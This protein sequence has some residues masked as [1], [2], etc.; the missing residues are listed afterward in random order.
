MR[1]IDHVRCNLVVDSGQPAIYYEGERLKN[2]DAIIP[3]IGASVTFHGA[4]II[5]QFEMLKIYT[6]ASSDALLRSRDKLRCLQ[7]LAMENLG[8]PK[9][10]YTDF[11][12]NV[13]KVIEAVGGTPL[14]IKLLEGTHGL[15][16]ILAETDKTAESI[17]DAFYKIKERVIVQ[18]FIEESKGADV[19]AFVVDGKIVAAMKRKALPGE[20]R[21]N[22]HRGGNSIHI[23]LTQ[24]EIDTALKATEVLGLDV[25][26]VDMLQSKRGP[27]VL[28][29][30]PSPGLE[31]ISRTTGIDVADKIIELVEQKIQ[32]HRRAEL[33][34]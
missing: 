3:R 32:A 14:I 34:M 33:N 26:G 11:S 18:E 16:V 1:I 24:A 29:V 4:A 23:K 6:A 12:P 27:L 5:R 20:F 10:V 17:L 7:L 13:K 30:N 9:T 15:G 25:A 8:V 2:I 28:E 31:G 21:S 22:L 19:R